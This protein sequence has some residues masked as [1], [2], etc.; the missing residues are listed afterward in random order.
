MIIPNHNKNHFKK[1]TFG[2][3]SAS[4]YLGLHFV[5]LLW[6]HSVLGPWFAHGF[7]IS[8]QA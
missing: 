7:Q 8:H 6:S 5:V 3:Y 2:V 1:C 4:I